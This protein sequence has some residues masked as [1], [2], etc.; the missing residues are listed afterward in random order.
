MHSRVFPLK[1]DLENSSEISHEGTNGGFNRFV[2]SVA[3]IYR[4]FHEQMRN[5]QNKAEVEA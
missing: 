4:C 2:A 3:V 5:F 1:F